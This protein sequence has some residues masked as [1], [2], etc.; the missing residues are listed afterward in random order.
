MNQ[1]GRRFEHT[2]SS[3]LSTVTPDEV[4]VTTVGYSGNAGIDACDIVVTVDPSL[5]TRHDTGQFN[6]ESKKAQ[7]ESGRRISN[8][9][10]G[11]RDDETGL[12]E[13]RRFVEHTPSWAQPVLAIHMDH[14][15]LIVVHGGRLLNHL[16][17]DEDSPHTPPE[18][19]IE[20]FEPR[21]TPSDSVSMVKP[22]TDQWPSATASEADEI[23]LATEL[24]LPLLT[25]D[26]DE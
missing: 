1:H 17:D 24:N 12:A 5:C 2:L 20:T 15:K 19:F 23:V 18:Q 16:D 13:L 22:E 6:I 21:L 9:L 14:R 7:G 11:G 10:A 3:G 25:G 26:D 8:I 4:W